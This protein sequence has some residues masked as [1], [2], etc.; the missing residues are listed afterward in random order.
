[1]YP[2]DKNKVELEELLIFA[3]TEFINF[4]QPNEAIEDEI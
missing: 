4:E 3:E 2:L 1:M